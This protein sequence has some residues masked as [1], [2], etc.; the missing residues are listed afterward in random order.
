MTRPWMMPTIMPASR[1]PPIDSKPAS[2]ATGNAAS[3]ISEAKKLTDFPLRQMIAPS[4]D[5]TE[6]RI[7]ANATDR[8]TQI[9]IETATGSEEHTPDLQSLMHISY[10]VS[11][12]KT[13]NQII[14]ENHII[15]AHE[16]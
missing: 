3:P 12:L 5:N 16:L 14:L 15:T 10:A 11:C 7:Q 1:T 2:R 6:T 13:K 9:P 8:W 4:V